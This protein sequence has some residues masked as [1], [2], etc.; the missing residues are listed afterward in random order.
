MA[1]ENYVAYVGTYTNGSSRGIHIYDVDVEE[2]LLFLRRVVPIRNSSYLYESRSDKCLYVVA[3]EGVQVL[4][5]QPD[6]DLVSINRI[7]MDGMRGHHM[8]QDRT[9]KYL[10]VAGYHDGKVTMIHTHRDG[11]LGSQTDGVYHKGIGGIRDRSWRPHVCCVRVSPD[12]R[13]LFAVDSALD[14]IVIYEIDHEA[15]KLKQIDILRMG[16]EVGP[17]SIWFSLDGRFAYVQ[18]EISCTVRVYA[19]GEK[20]DGFP[21]FDLIEE[22]ST[23]GRP[24]EIHDTGASLRLSQDGNYLVASTAGEDTVTIFEINHETGG[25]RRI[26]TL[27]T[28]GT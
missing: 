11:R 15:G 21:P 24:F 17:R 1:K 18:C 27:P 6:G 8:T 20:K 23:L 3:D 9:G 26:L 13:F 7:T 12:N 14:Q 5:I 2:G 19:L 22:H 16:K 28:S 10:F 25:L 4:G